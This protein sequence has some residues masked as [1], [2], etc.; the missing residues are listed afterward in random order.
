VLTF[1]SL[2]VSI[3]NSEIATIINAIRTDDQKVDL[4][5]GCD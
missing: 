2:I 4:A 3:A 1:Y 5:A